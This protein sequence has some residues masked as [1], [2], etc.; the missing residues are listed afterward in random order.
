VSRL[1]PRFAALRAEGRAGLVTFIMGGD[2]DYATALAILKGLPQAGADVIEIGMPF[3]DP[4]ADGPAI[5]AAGLRALNG[6]MTL[7]RTLEMVSEFR[8]SDINTPIVLMG[9]FNPI[10]SYGA[11]KFVAAAKNAGVDGLIIVDLPPEE[12]AELRPQANEAGIDIIRLCAP[13]TDDKRLPA[14]LDGA[15][16]FLYY[17]S[18]LGPTGVKSVATDDVAKAV[19]RLRRHTKLPIAVG[20]GI[21]T[22]EAAAGV[23]R[24][25]D[26]AVVGTALVQIIADRLDAHGKPGADTVKA[27]HDFVRRLSSAVRDARQPEPAGS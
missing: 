19:Q 23:A 2:P 10:Y 22:P 11:D 12:D 18:V 1:G 13:T 25:A 5:Q 9:Y 21:K 8:K 6:G 14:V 3:S 7:K 26:A 4:M 20:F 27:A 15:S 24:N 17:V 16:G